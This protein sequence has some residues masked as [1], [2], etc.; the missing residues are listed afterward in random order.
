MSAAEKRRGAAPLCF[1]SHKGA[2]PCVRKA[3]EVFELPLGTVD[4]GK[5]GDWI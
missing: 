5:G 4:H 1:G 2:V 3:G